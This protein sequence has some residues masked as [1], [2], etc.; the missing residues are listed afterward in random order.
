MAAAAKSR[1]CQCGSEPNAE[2]RD[3]RATRFFLPT[4]HRAPVALSAP[5]RC[6]NPCKYRGIRHDRPLM[7][8]LEQYPEIW[9]CVQVLLTSFEWRERARPPCSPAVPKTCCAKRPSLA[10]PEHEPNTLSAGS[11]I[12]TAS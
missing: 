9:T 1:E 6:R 10:A 2:L 11:I 5:S 3:R 4:G 8:A 12:T 7:E